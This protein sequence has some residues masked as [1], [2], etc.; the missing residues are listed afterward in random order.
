[1]EYLGHVVTSA[2]LKVNHKRVQAIQEFPNPTNVTEVRRFLGLSSY[3][4]RF[5]QQFSKI[6]EPLRALT[7]KDV[8]FN[9]TAECQESMDQLKRKLISSPVLAYPSF[10]KPFTLE[11]A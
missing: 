3:Y 2:G 6:A 11:T 5:I 8:K 7:R 1:M 10:E 9:W 4:R